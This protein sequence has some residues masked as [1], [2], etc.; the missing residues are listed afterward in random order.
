MG[1]QTWQKSEQA[2]IE[3]LSLALMNQVHRRESNFVL[4]NHWVILELN[5]DS[6]WFWRANVDAHGTTTN[7][8][9]M[10]HPKKWK[11]PNF[12]DK[13]DV[14]QWTRA[15]TIPKAVADATFRSQQ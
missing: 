3:G 2:I 1:Y 14:A 4:G 7:Q 13:E 10:Q 9:A 5:E 15:N 11:A 6:H 12:L 8:I